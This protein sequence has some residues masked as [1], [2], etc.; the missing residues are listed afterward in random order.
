[1][2]I[3]GTFVG[4][5]NM[6]Y[7]S[8][9]TGAR[10]SS[11]RRRRLYLI[12]K[13]HYHLPQNAN[14]T[15]AKLWKREILILEAARTDCG[16]HRKTPSVSKESSERERLI[17]NSSLTRLPDDFC[18]L[19]YRHSAAAGYNK[20]KIDSH[21]HTHMVEVGVVA[22][23]RHPTSERAL[24]GKEVLSIKTS[25]ALFINRIRRH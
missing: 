9:F 24:R 23:R 6:A 22:K 5:R 13:C 20:P 2:A 3:N 19:W 11:H 4:G 8:S 16:Y 1:M 7:L 18:Q 21:T 12:H 10:T 14:A 15:A 25:N 17:N